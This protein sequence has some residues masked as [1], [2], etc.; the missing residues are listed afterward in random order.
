MTAIPEGASGEHRWP[1]VAALLVALALY[2]ALPSTFLPV[3]RYAVVGIGLLLLIPLLVVNPVRMH[4]QTAWTRGISVAQALLLAAANQVMLVELIVSLVEPAT[5]SGTRLLL[6][7]AQ[8]WLTNVIAFALVMWELD[9]GGPVVRRALDRAALPPADIRFAQDEDHDAIEEVAAASSRVAGWR[10][11]FGDYLYSSLS[12]SMAFSAS[13]SIP[14]SGRAKALMGLQ[15]FS[16]FV[17]LALVIARAVS[18]VSA[19]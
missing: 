2:L 18:L 9:R 7:A 4:R 17:L 16:G 11:R 1:A 19:S 3:L 13:D 6:S 10:P 14:L 8:V 12:N 5:G 15:A